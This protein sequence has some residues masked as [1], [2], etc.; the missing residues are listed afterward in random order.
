LS[1]LNIIITAQS[2]VNLPLDIRKNI[3][4]LIMFKPAKK[5][6]EIV[7]KENTPN[8]EQKVLLETVGSQDQIACATGGINHIEFI[9][10]NIWKINKICNN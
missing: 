4:N 2:Y 9:S 8:Y 6:L 3:Q 10:N 7:A 1:K 5:E